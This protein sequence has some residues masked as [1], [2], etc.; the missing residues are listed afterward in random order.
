[1]KRM[2]SFITGYDEVDFYKD[3]ANINRIGFDAKTT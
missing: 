1:M 2:M 3:Y